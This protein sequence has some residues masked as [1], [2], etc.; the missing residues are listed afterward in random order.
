M[1]P[2]LLFFLRML[3]S[4]PVSVTV[5]LFSYF[6][7]DQ[8]FILSGA[9]GVGAGLVTYWMS[10]VVMKHRFIKSHGMKRKEYLYIEKNL[11]EA[12]RKLDRLHKALISIRHLP[13]LRQR[14]EFIKVTRRIYRLTKKEPRR[15]YQAEQFYFSHLDSA[16]ELA[17]R[18]VFLSSQPSKTRDLENSLNETRKTLKELTVNVEKDL[19]DVIANDI[20]QLHFEIDVAKHSI[21]KIKDSRMNDE[22]RRLK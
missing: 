12:K 20:D 22:S 6:A 21:K 10:G 15:F 13:S 8:T 19:H 17:E 1:N 11:D 14:M 9:I 5:W 18:Y 4:V 7:F 16:V 3:I 2:F